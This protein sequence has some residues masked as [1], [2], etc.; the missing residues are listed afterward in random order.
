MH[1]IFKKQLF[2]MT[3]TNLRLTLLAQLLAYF[4]LVG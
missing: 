2:S 4:W 3:L 1:H